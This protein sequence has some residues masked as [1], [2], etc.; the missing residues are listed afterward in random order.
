MVIIVLAVPY[1]YLFQYW[2]PRLILPAVVLFAI[3]VAWLASHVLRGRQRLQIAL[4]AGS[5]FQ[6]IV[7]LGVIVGR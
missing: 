7:H 5:I 2:H 1:A 3:P 4:L 6:A